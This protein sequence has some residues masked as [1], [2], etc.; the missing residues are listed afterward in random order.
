M[1]SEDQ[2]DLEDL[3]ETGPGELP[4]LDLRPHF[5]LD[6]SVTFLNHGSFGACPRRIQHHQSALRTQMDAEP[7]RFFTR[8]LPLLLDRVRA[9]FGEFLGAHP[10]RLAMI[11][12]TTGGVNAVLRS[13][14]FEAGDEILVTDQGYGACN[15]TAQFVA[16]RSGARVVKAKL[17]Y[18][19]ET[20]EEITAAICK[21]VTAKTKIAMVDHITSS[22]G[23]VFPIKEIVAA[24]RERGVD[25]LV[26]GAHA[27]GMVALDLDDLG[28]AYYV[29]NCH[30]WL[31]TPRGAAFLYVR[32]DLV[33]KVRPTSISHGAMHPPGLERFRAEF[34]WTGTYDPTAIL[35]IP[36]TLKFLSSLLPNKMEGIYARNRALAIHARRR[37][38]DVVGT[39][40]ICPESMLGSLAAVELP[41]GDGPLAT[42]VMETDPLQ[43]LLFDEAGIE[44]PIFALHDPP[45][46]LLRISAALYNIEKDYEILCTSLQNLGALHE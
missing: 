1:E 24:L 26:D 12:N 20:P 18:P 44:V 16:D 27:P 40:P 38:L 22:T 39:A 21:A 6:Y 46:R 42:S 14:E 29:G 8:E 33:E 32:P 10:D 19:V 45:R 28:A 34:D 2:H 7:V 37:L 3:E 30:K 13:M 17:P 11:P 15:L 9:E 36:E 25:T 5:S 4:G 31:C 43:K 35:A 23:I 41:P